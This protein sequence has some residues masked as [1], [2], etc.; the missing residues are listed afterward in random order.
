MCVGHGETVL[1]DDAI[2]IQKYYEELRGTGRIGEVNV[3]TAGSVVVRVNGNR[4][5]SGHTHMILLYFS[6]DW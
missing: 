5:G 3:N 6:V 4:E 2:R 1:I